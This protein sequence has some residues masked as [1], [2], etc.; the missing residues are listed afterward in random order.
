MDTLLISAASG[1]KA[2]MESLDMLANNLAN[3]ETAGFKA[4]SEFFN[5]YQQQLPVIEQ[6]WTNFSQGTLVAT[7]NPLHVALSGKGFLAVN[8]P[9]GAVYT[10][11]GVLQITKANE[12][13]TPDGYTVRNALNQGK[14]MQVDPSAT[15]VIDKAGIVSQNGEVIGQMEL[16]RIPSAADTLKKLGNSYFALAGHGSATAERD[17]EVMQGQLE[18][19]NVT[20]ADSAVRL[21]NVMR[22]FEMLQKAMAIGSQMNKQAVQQVARVG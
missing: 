2:R 22:Q 4:D 13:A 14:P 5:L 8:G 11:S 16:V 20:V 9:A 17:T 1:I 3:S 21:I 7:G 19:S 18:Q 12:L 15:V 6:Q 10:R